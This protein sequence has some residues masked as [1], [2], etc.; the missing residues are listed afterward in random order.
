[1]NMYQL[2]FGDPA[3]KF[4]KL[5]RPSLFFIVVAMFDTTVMQFYS[6]LTCLHSTTNCNSN[7]NLNN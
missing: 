5:A 6:F 1:M 2:K 4:R 7:L 3:I